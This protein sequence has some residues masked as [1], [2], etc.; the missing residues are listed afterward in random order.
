MFDELRNIFG[1]AAYNFDDIIYEQGDKDRNGF[2]LVSGNIELSREHDGNLIE[3][4]LF[5][6]EGQ[7][8]GVFTAI[9]NTEHRRWTATA[10]EKS[11][12]IKIPANVIES[13]IKKLIVLI[14][15][16]SIVYPNGIRSNI[17]GSNLGHK[18]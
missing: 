15:F 18:K 5:I 4:G 7:V 13:K 10:I 3:R 2:V 8:F 16:S 14:R 11:Q 12:I 1:T 17:L 9:F 6:T